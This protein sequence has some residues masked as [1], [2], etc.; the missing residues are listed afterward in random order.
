MSADTYSAL[1]DAI[2]AHISDEADGDL[3]LLTDWYLISASVSED[4]TSTI[5]SHDCSDSGNH[6]L[7]GLTVLA[8]RRILDGDLDAVDDD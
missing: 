6:A 5:Y 3:R 2:Q 7:I 8:H 1:V 4:T